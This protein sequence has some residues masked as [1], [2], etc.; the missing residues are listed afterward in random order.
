[1]IQSTEH[2]SVLIMISVAACIYHVTNIVF[3]KF[4]YNKWQRWNVEILSLHAS[5]TVDGGFETWIV[6]KLKTTKLAL[7]L[8]WQRLCSPSK[9]F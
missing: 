5:R 8:S 4:P 2:C 7:I 1:M 6:W 9:V 3:K